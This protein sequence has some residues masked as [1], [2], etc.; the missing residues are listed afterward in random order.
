MTFEI[1]KF[2]VVVVVPGFII[3]LVMILMGE[4]K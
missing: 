2:F 3:G 1:W 4:R